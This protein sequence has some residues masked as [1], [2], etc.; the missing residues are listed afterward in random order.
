MKKTALSTAIFVFA[1]N[2]L[3]FARPLIAAVPFG[4]EEDY[5]AMDNDGVDPSDDD[6][7]AAHNGELSATQGERRSEAKRAII[8]GLGEASPWNTASLSWKQWFNGPLAWSF[9]AGTGRFRQ[10]TVASL[11]RTNTNVKSIGGRVQWWPAGQFPV[12]L[13]SDLG[14]HQ[15]KIKTDCITGEATGACTG[16]E[17]RANGGSIAE[18]IM[19]SWLAEEHFVFE[20]TV[21]SV[22]WSRTFSRK[23]DGIAGSH[24]E[25]EAL[26][27]IRTTQVLS[28]AN[29][30]LGWRF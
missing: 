2:L 30:G 11:Y 8:L 26:K 15:W 14:L 5:D 21:L 7:R 25:E 9:I 24:A 4:E 20:W 1:A 16:G 22:K 12:A 17:L 6:W 19:V 28:I 27:S 3:V 13:V 23:W 10:D 18:G 29:F